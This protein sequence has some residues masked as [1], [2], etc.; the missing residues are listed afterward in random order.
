MSQSAPT[1]SLDVFTYRRT[2]TMVD[3]H[4]LSDYACQVWREIEQ[5]KGSSCIT[6]EVAK[7]VW[8]RA[9]VSGVK[10]ETPLHPTVCRST[11][12]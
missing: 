12:H 3:E 6:M 5:P 4:D 1:R 2:Q 7:A 10:S 11:P 9:G 8:C